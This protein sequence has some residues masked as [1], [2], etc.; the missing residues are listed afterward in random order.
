MP[1]YKL[2]SSGKSVS[3][4]DKDYVAA[5]GEGTIYTQGGVAYKVCLPG[6][7]MPE[8][9]INELLPLAKQPHIIVPYDIMLD[10]K[11]NKVGYAMP[12]VPQ[13]KCWP[14]AQTFT[15]SFKQREGL[16]TQSVLDMVDFMKKSIDFIHQNKILVVDMNEFNFLVSKA[17]DKV[18]FIDTNSYQTKSYPATAIMD[19]IK[20]RHI[21]KFSELSDWFSFGIISFEMMIGIHPFRGGSHPRFTNASVDDRMD[22]RMKANVSVLNPDTK[23]PKGATQ[24]LSVIPQGYLDWYKAIFEKGLRVPPPADFSGHVLVV[25]TTPTLSSDS[26]ELKLYKTFDD[27]ITDYKIV[28]GVEIFITGVKNKKVHLGNNS[29]PLPSQMEIVHHNNMLIG[30]H[31]NGGLVE[32]HNIINKHGLSFPAFNMNASQIMS[33]DNRVYAQCGDKIV[34]ILFNSMGANIIPSP[35]I[36]GH[37]SENST[38]MFRGLTIQNWFGSNFVSIFPKSKQ[39]LQFKISEIDNQIVIDGE[40]SN[41]IAVISTRAKNGSKFFRHTIK[42]SEDFTSYVIISIDKASPVDVNYTVLDNGIAVLLNENNDLELFHSSTKSSSVKIVDDKALAGN[43]NIYS[44]GAKVLI[45]KGEKLY[46]ASLKK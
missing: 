25:T 40:Y 33:Y 28:N 34:E 26:L 43:V 22:L 7:M 32:F 42:F 39:S 41:G 27:V 10:N 31:C 12:F 23:Y 13:N 24:S 3:I 36:V 14:L 8:G 2:Q 21:T 6:K 5:G 16:D 46:E 37:T 30:V 4:T 29:Y 11:G 9:K 38:K 45:S 20:D 44:R 17:F 18:Y 19:S 15:N 1:N 35:H